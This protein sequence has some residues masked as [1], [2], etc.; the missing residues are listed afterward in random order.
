M[1]LNLNDRI[2]L[3]QHATMQTRITAAV[4]KYALYI[5]GNV[6]ATVNQLAWA[7]EAI[8][9]PASV[10][11]Q[12]SYHVLDNPDFLAGGSDITD[13]QLQGACEA[14]INSRFIAA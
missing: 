6:N 8:R 13:A 3:I 10:G 1:A 14:A 2:V 12:V 7:R 4:A 5:L 9:S 11:N